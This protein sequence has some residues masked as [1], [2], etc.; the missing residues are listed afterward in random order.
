MIV[1]LCTLELFIPD[2]HS[3]K[4]KRK[5]VQS[6]ITRVRGRH[7]VSVSEV[8]HQDL[9]QRAGIAIAAVGTSRRH[10]ESMFDGI[11]REIES[12]VPAQIVAHDV[13]FL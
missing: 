11:L 6:L 2:A 13:D 1:G 12:T 5:V 9:W 4:E 8:E 7:N 10:L 3:L